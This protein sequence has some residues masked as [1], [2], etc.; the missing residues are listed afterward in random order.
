MWDDAELSCG[1]YGQKKQW[2]KKIVTLY[3]KDIQQ[4]FVAKNK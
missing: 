4:I 3:Q 1:A 2:Y